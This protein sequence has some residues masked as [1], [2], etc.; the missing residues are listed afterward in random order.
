MVRVPVRVAPTLGSKVKVAKPLT[1][2]LEVVCS[3]EA[4]DAA[5]QAPAVVTMSESVPL[6]GPS[7]SAVV[8]SDRSRRFSSDST[9]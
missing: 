1:A 3:Q 7:T 4:L 9:A 6:A 8:P 5:V 2:P